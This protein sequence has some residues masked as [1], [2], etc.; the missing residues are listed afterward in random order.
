MPGDPGNLKPAQ[1][2]RYEMDPRPHRPVLPGNAQW[3]GPVTMPP[4]IVL[5]RN[6][7]WERH[8]KMRKMQAARAPQPAAGH[9]SS[10]HQ[11]QQPGQGHTAPEPQHPILPGNAEWIPI[12]R[13][14]AGRKG[15]A[16]RAP[17]PACTQASS[18]LPA[19]WPAEGHP[20][21]T[22]RDLQRRNTDRA[23]AVAQALEPKVAPAEFTVL[24]MSVPDPR[25][26]LK[27]VGRER[28]LRVLNILRALGIA[29]LVSGASLMPGGKIQLVC[30]AGAAETVRE[31]LVD[32]NATLHNIMD[33]FARPPHSRLTPEKDLELTACRLAL[34]CRLSRA[35]NYH[36]AVLTGASPEM[37]QAA[38]AAFCKITKNDQA[39][40][41]HEGRWYSAACNPGGDCE[42]D[43]V[44]EATSI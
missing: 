44:M 10:Q 40:L 22:L 28:D 43:T 13:H 36:E 26:I 29:P 14:V 15:S 30:R 20:A 18:Q 1:P 19:Q 37:R 35:R 7:E 2:A 5:P 21:L 41:G 33:P 17:Q 4:H 3:E 25:S 6:A 12:L 8:V 27:A 39:L 31:V 38:T 32:T 11:V 16:A 34:L 9:P 42:G 24:Y 23:K